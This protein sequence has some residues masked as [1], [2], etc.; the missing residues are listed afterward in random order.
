M[1]LGKSQV[2]GEGQV[3]QGT[4][5]NGVCRPA[6]LAWSKLHKTIGQQVHGSHTQH[7][8]AHTHTQQVTAQ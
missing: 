4:Q 3:G 8:T 2:L 6:A 5:V 1:V 7:L